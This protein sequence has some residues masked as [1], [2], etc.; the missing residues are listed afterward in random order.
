MEGN[1]KYM[2]RLERTLLPFFNGWRLRNFCIG[3]TD[4]ACDGWKLS[5][6]REN[7]DGSQIPLEWT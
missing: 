7:T 3:K 1:R 5:D 2:V 6:I 4:M